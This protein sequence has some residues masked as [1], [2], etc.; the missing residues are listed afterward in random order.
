METFGS[1]RAAPAR[2]ALR[3][4][5]LG[6]F[7]LSFEDRPVTAVDAP[8][9]QSLL[10][11]LV[12][13]R[14]T[15]Q[16]REQLA[17]LFWP[18]SEESQARTN[19]RQ[20]LHLLRRALPESR[21]FLETETRTVRWRVD[22]PV[23]L[24]V[25]AF[26]GLLAAAEEA[27][28]GGE[29]GDE[30]SALESALALYR[31]D[32]L[33][34]CYDDWIVPERERLR[35]RFLAAGERLTELL[36]G[37]R[38][39][40][41]AIPWARRLLDADPLNEAACRR[42]M[43]LHA[44]TGDR[45]TALRAYHGCATALAREVGVDPSPAT[46]EVYQRLLE[47]EELPA[48]EPGRAGGGV[49]PLVG[50][51]EEW[52]VLCDAWRRAAGRQSLLA[53]I[54]GEAGIGKS[55]LAEELREWLARQ[56]IQTA[57]TRCYPAGRGLAYAPVVELL[58]T[59]PLRPVIHGL[60]DP[61]R[62]EL[63]RLVPELVDE[64]SVEAA[65]PLTDAWQR[66]RLFDALSRAFLPG[67]EPLLLAIDDLQW[68][69]RETLEW[70][71]HLLRSRPD[72]PL[73]VLG[74]ARPEEVELEH[75]LEALLVGARA[76][77]QAVEVDLGPLNPVDTLALARNLAGHEL[78]DVRGRAVFDQTEGNPLFVVE[79]VR[80]GFF[81]APPAGPSARGTASAGQL[82]PRAQALIEARLAQLSPAGQELASL[83]ATVGRAFAFDVLAAASSRP[84]EQVVEA[85]DELWQRRIVRERGDDYDFS[86]DKLREAAYSRAG[87]ATRRL[88]HRRVAQALERLLAP[89]LDP[90][91]AQ[92]AVHYEHGGWPARAIDFYARAAA[93]A[94]RVYANEGAIDLFSSA[95]DLLDAEP[96][97]RHRD[98]RELA[99]RT[100][101]GAALVA[102]NGYGA[103]E[104]FDT[105]RRA[106]ELCERLGTR[107]D[108]PVVRALALANLTR[109]EA[110]RA[111]DLGEQLLS[112]GERD[113]DPMVRVEGHYLLGVMSFWLADLAA[114][115]T[116]LEHAI[117][118]YVPERARAHVALYSQ[119]PRVVCLSRLAYT[120]W[121]L[122]R[123]EEADAL[124]REAL[125][126]AE[127]LDHPFSLAYALTFAV[128]LAIDRGDERRARECAERMAAL[129]DEQ[130]LGF[131]QPMGA[132]FR[133]W[134]LAVEGRADQ[135][136]A[137]IRDGLDAYSRSGWSL[138]MPWAL[139]LLA[140]VS[141]EHG[142][143]D[144]ARGAVS[145]ALE[146]IESTGQ[147]YL[148]P[149]VKRLRGEIV[150][151]EGGDRA[152]AE[153]LFAEALEIAR[154]EGSPPLEERAAG[155]LERLRAAAG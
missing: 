67:A 119:D 113:G 150:L 43:T 61:W 23:E 49:S 107:P 82:P 116:H 39:F 132:I 102:I 118:G 136:I 70:L 53:L 141:L 96:P 77:G 138:Y 30:R 93:A 105:Y 111:Y 13:H 84:E 127:E 29:T 64:H 16:P 126:R 106:W 78:D 155:S 76:S 25:A 74:T 104:V 89:D 51:A 20:A 9:L 47:S 4:H 94:Q 151:A 103:S 56:G 50:R 143:L 128:W 90:V 125:R 85:L 7:S 154:R 57:A 79:S 115:R 81:D 60:G 34:G 32:L 97:G 38:E 71:H 80:A 100:A 140:R 46:R 55:R 5:L 27:H 21:R 145:E 36:E 58:R 33:P 31:G 124:A 88:A 109:G 3:V 123:P 8:R 42:V 6:S 142:R 112:A 40:R 147:R 83:A 19:L 11:H 139:T 73:L 37:E 35:G 108:P 87:P 28:E 24:D 22:A 137:R 101:L 91:S 26:E 133:G 99:L 110:T 72:A 45:A 153:A 134:M 148:E 144:T 18:D 120:L 12:L 135:A 68:C 146:I 117:A 149:E 129:A 65:P 44:L 48:P 152:D 62:V 98:E 10:G 75:P 2:P 95:L 15:P 114:A 131:L 17:F 52:R 14:D 41:A 122:G 59:E 86:H 1:R 66:A 121:Y 54:A 92:L 63:A 130:R 69:D